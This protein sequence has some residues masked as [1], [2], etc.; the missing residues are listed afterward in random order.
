MSGVARARALTTPAALPP[1][2]Q[3][4]AG[5]VLYASL[6]DYPLTLTQLRQTLIE[7][8]QTPTEILAAFERSDAL[9]AIIAFEEGYFFP[10]GRADL[11][12]E[13]RRRSLR[14]RRFLARHRLFLAAVCALPYVRLVALSGSIAHM[15]LEGTGDLDL[16]IVTRGRHVWSVTVAVVLLAKLFHR[17]RTVCANYVLADS[18]LALDQQDLFSASQI[19]HLKPLVGAGVYA[20]LLAANP[21]VAR[22]YPNFHPGD[23]TRLAFK[24]GRS[25]RICKRGAERL[26]AAPAAL[27]E[28]LCRSAYR[29]Y[30]LR[31][32]SVWRSP[33]QVRLDDDRLKLHTQS[34]RRSV[35]ERFHDAV[36][37]IAG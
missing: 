7:S 11:I 17:R 26:L 3:S 13:R 31:R 16:F 32:S 1:A 4:I 23:S 30:L 36:R 33:E 28:R 10:R 21:F 24:P 12:A 9:R 25:L 8:E 27:A 15:N 22:F 29:R 35:L 37:Q 19:I 20:E 34:H 18:A 14:S 5:S 6:F 2:E